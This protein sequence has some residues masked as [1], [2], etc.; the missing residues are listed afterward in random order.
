MGAHHRPR[1]RDDV[2]E[3]R[4][5]HAGAGQPPTP[6][7]WA[8]EH[9]PSA[10]YEVLLPERA[11]AVI[12]RLEIVHTPPHGSWLNVAECELSVLGRQALS[13]RIGDEAELRRITEGWSSEWTAAQKGVEWQFTTAEA[14]VKLRHLSPSYS[15]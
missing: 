11:R 9:K 1:G 13:R 2:P 5:D 10:L 14:R 4:A 3:G 7:R 6:P 12:A 8:G 15:M